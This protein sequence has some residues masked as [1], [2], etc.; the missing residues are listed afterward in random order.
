M[1]LEWLFD[2]NIFGRYEQQLLNL[3]RGRL[4]L[5]SVVAQ[6]LLVATDDNRRR[7]LLTIF[8]IFLNA[9]LLLNP[10][11]KDW[12]EVGERLRRLSL[13][14]SRSGTRLSKGETNLLVR[15]AL[16]A[17][18]A[19]TRNRLHRQNGFQ[20]ECVIVTENLSD[21]QKVIEGT[22][23]KVLAGRELFGE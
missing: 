13:G 4:V 1:A 11:H 5:S 18:C 2:T 22:H 15:D 8:N 16:I 17:Q 10:T 7:R 14:Y 19:V 6:E 12:L 9:G 21:F 20:Y 23:L 3:R